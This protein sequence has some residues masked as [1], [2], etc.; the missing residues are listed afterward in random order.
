MGRKSDKRLLTS[1]RREE[2]KNME[3]GWKFGISY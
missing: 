3:L 1:G 2:K